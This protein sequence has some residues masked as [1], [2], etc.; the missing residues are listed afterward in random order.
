M[1]SR[2][3]LKVVRERGSGHSLIAIIFSGS[4]VT[5]AGEMLWPKYFTFVVAKLHLESLAKNNLVS[6]KFIISS[7]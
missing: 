6:N 4:G 7:K 2:N 1:R 5:T 3:A